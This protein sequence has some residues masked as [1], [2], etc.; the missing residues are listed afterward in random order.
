[1]STEH[2]CAGEWKAGKAHACPA[3]GHNKQGRRQRR[4]RG[5]G[6]DVD[7]A[8]GVIGVERDG[9]TSGRDSGR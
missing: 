4:V 1:M 9:F 8:A 7:Q 5:M 6:R 2:M 3:P